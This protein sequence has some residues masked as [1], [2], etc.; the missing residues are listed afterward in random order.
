MAL[1]VDLS[2]IGVGHGL[3]EIRSAEKVAITGRPGTGKSRLLDLVCGL[4]EPTYGQV[5]VDGI[6]LRH[7][8]L[9]GVR[10]RIALV[11]EAEIIGGTVLENLRV[12]REHLDLAEVRRALDA[13]GLQEAI[14]ALPR[15]LETR[16]VP[17]GYPLSSSQALRLSIARGL[18][19]P[20]RLL[21]LDG[22]L[23]GLNLTD[24]PGLL[25]ALFDPT[26]PWTLLV[27]TSREDVIAR[28]DRT[29]SLNPG[30]AD[31]PV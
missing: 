22:V 20:P 18:L 21:I 28:C 13:V 12:G 27:V 15:G 10:E 9:E 6:D 8:R 16:L 26:A 2:Q 11:K 24:S 1:R 5:R 4:R 25:P 7:L 30:A 14:Q 23:D 3:W 29:V 31:A 19:G 17:D